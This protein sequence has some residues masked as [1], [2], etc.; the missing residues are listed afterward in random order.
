MI[1]LAN[2]LAFW[3][4]FDGVIP[5]QEIALFIQLI[6]WLVLIRGIIF[7]PLRLYQGLWRYTGI[8]DLRNVIYGVFSSTAVF[9]FLVH[10]GLGLPKYPLSVFIIDSL[11]LIFFMT[12]I[13][14]ASC[15]S[16]PQLTLLKGISIAE[17]FYPE[18]HLR[19]MRDIDLLV[20]VESLAPMATLLY[21]LG[22][23]QTS[24]TP[25]KTYDSHHH[26]MPFFH[27]EKQVWVELHHRLISAKNHGS[28]S[29]NPAAP[30]R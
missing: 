25:H 17:E 7:I 29:A 19:P 30:F 20:P 26:A 5:D 2:Y 10:W 28:R 11:L 15:G 23:R 9:Y 6:P 13:I 24:D 1:G 3:I 16:V 12:E 4:R 21:G 22:Y 14:D 27:D 18:F 8:W